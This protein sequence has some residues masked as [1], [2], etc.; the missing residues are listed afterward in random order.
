MRLPRLAR[1]CPLR[2]KAGAS[3]V[4]A[5]EQGD[6][7]GL[8]TAGSGPGQPR[9]PSFPWR[10]FDRGAAGDSAVFDAGQGLQFLPG[11]AAIC[12]STTGGSIKIYGAPSLETGLFTRGYIK[13][14]GHEERRNQDERQWG[15]GSVLRGPPGQ[16][17]TGDGVTQGPPQEASAVRGDCQRGPGV[18]EYP[19]R[20]VAQLR[21]RACFGSGRSRAQTRP[22]RPPRGV[23]SDG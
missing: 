17:R 9:V 12:A 19:W 8:A 4:S 7:S 22:P 21:W 15:L 2:G 13:R 3:R 6:V 1:A 23:M 5:R 18:L 11:I 16:Q 10:Y 14:V 20:G